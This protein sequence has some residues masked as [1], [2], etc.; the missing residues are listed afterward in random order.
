MKRPLLAAALA[1]VLVAPAM[2]NDTT[3][4]LAAGG[5]VLTKTD[6]IE[7]KSEDLYVST[8]AV[9]VTYRFLNT[10][11]KDVTTR[12]A[13]PMPDVGGP[14]FQYRITAIPNPTDGANVLDFKTVVDGKPVKMEVEQKAFVKGVDRTAWL[15]KRG[16][17][18]AVYLPGIGAKL[19]ALSKSDKAEAL[20]LGLVGMEEYEDDKGVLQRHLHPAWT[21]KTTF[22]WEQ[23]FPAGRELVV[24]HSY[25]PA[26][27]GSAGTIIGQQGFGATDE[28]REVQKRY[29]VDTVFLDAVVRIKGKLDYPP[30]S[31][32]R[33]AYVLK[34]G[35]NWAK[36]IGDFRLVVDK[37]SPKNLVSFCATDTKKIGPTQF[38][39]RKT[40]WTPP[41]DL[42][43]LILIPYPPQE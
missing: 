11:G 38:E 8:E 21:V 28:W 17:P 14:E 42:N 24:Q 27:G 34:T 23:T 22:H 15:T 37:G 26:A 13:F 5:L 20:A 31:E 43:V 19:D 29:C 39:I 41:R 12:V 9:R 4:E 6:A 32:A 33:I 36:P 10:S 35:G 25:R 7:M 2:A 16:V 30:F 18:L 3:A 1:A 40:N